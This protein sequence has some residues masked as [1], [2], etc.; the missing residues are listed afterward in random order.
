MRILSVGDGEG[1]VEEGPPAHHEVARIRIDRP[2][3]LDAATH[4]R[5][6]FEVQRPR[7]TAGDLVLSYREVST[8]GLEPFCPQ[9]RTVFS[10]DQLH[11]YPNLV[12]RPSHAA[13][14]DV[15]YS[16]FAAEPLQ[17]DGFAFVS[18]RGVAGDHEAARNPREIGR[19]IVGDAVHEILLVW[20]VRQV[21]EGQYDDR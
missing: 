6:E 7:E 3:F 2:F 21:R 13:L 5:H 18:K 19:Q 9:M 10:I 4:V 12:I 20:V 11:V 15:M 17:V 16:E 1:P 14:E 8:I